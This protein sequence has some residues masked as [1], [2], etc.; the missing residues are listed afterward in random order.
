MTKS[1]DSP[2]LVYTDVLDKIHGITSQLDHEIFED[3]QRGAPHIANDMLRNVEQELHRR[4]QA[5]QQNA[6]WKTFT[7][8]FC[9][10][11][12]AGKSTLV[13]CLRILFKESS[14]QEQHKAFHALQKHFG[15]YEN[16]L[17]MLDQQAEKYTQRLEDIQSDMTNA[18]Q[19]Y[20]QQKGELIRNVQALQQNINEKK[21]AAR[22]LSRILSILHRLPEETTLQ[23]L[24]RQITQLPQQYTEEVARL[25]QQQQLAQSG[26]EHVMRQHRLALDNRHQLAPFEDGLIIND[27]HLETPREINRYT[28]EYKGQP[29][30]VLDVPG[31]DACNGK[32]DNH[33]YVAIER[34]HAVFYVTSKATALQKNAEAPSS[35][36][37]KISA[38]LGTQTEVW[39]LFNKHVTDPIALRNPVLVGVDEQASLADLDR[40]MRKMLGTHYR[41]SVSLSAFPAFLAVSDCLIPLSKK[42]L[43]RKTF[44]DVLTAQQLLDASGVEKFQQLFIQE[45]TKE[46]NAKIR[47]SNL[48][49]VS[50]AINATCTGMERLVREQFL[51]LQEALH[52]EA[53]YAERQMQLAQNNLNKN[54]TDV[55]RC[56]IM[57]FGTH[58]RQHIYAQIENDITN[59]DFE[60]KLYAIM[61]QQQHL[62]QEGLPELFDKHVEQFKTQVG[63]IINRFEAHSKAILTR[64]EEFTHT[65]AVNAFS[66]D[67]DMGNGI[68]LCELMT[69]FADRALMHWPSV[70]WGIMSMDTITLMTGLFKSIWGFFNDDYRQNQQRKAVEKNIRK[71]YKELSVAFRQNQQIALQPLVEKMC[72]ITAQLQ[73]PVANIEHLCTTID[74]VSLRLKQVARGVI[75]WDSTH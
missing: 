44:F 66:T 60:S 74:S 68:D 39:T 58:V 5:L 1:S 16:D 22:P 2:S 63:N 70:G 6:E 41:R 35:T 51:L 29:F 8:A 46:Y 73:E 45:L 24:Q 42:A 67:V 59:E 33:S 64:H 69:S 56:A 10:E 49:K 28:F 15:L 18:G 19:Q 26:R 34:A 14:K 17:Q 11:H 55:G 32:S 20:E 7:V 38:Y 52:K 21:R 54:I 40:T 37:E 13:E 25:Q 43:R 57:T 62:I 12:N 4:I 50:A 53:E 23:Q 30:T 31:L 27:E 75:N 61:A 36:L 65:Q 9:G 72:E 47:R 48:N 71:A 3:K